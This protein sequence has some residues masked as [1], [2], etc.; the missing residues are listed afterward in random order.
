M[1]GSRCGTSPGALGFADRRPDAPEPRRDSG[2]LAAVWSEGAPERAEFAD[3]GSLA[4]VS[5]SDERAEL[6]EAVRAV[7]AAV[8][9][10]APSWECAVVVP[11]VDDVEPAAAALQGCRAARGLPRAG[12]VGGRARAGQAGR[13]PGA[14]GR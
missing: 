8:A 12:E 9:G 1:P 11:H 7:L 3:D 5:V 10:G 14:A 2:L 6:R 4:V 13:L